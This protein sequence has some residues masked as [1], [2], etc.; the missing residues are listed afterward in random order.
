M[1]W[2]AVTDE[3]WALV[4]P[5]LP[6]PKRHRIGGGRPRVCDRTVLNAILFV[7]TT[8]CQWKALSS[9]RLC[10]P[11]TAHDRF[12]E[13]RQA[14]VF[15]DLWAVG[16]SLYDEVQGIDWRW[17]CLDGCMTKAPLAGTEDAGPNPTD[18][19]K[20]GVKRSLLTDA[21][22]VPLAVGV[23]G[24]NRPDLALALD[25]LDDIVVPR[26]RPSLE[27][28]QGLC[29]DKGYD[30]LWLRWEI[31]C[32][33]YDPHIRTRGEEAKDRRAEPGKKA[34]RWPVERTHSWINRFRRLLIRWE[35]RTDNF[36]AMLHFAFALICVQRAAWGQSG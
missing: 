28:P 33:Q 26:P 8:G 29:L 21:A 16:L 9:T 2:K 4:E 12:Q 1:S 7:L 13:W 32:R 14:G 20:L 6:A 27:F 23:A 25:T 3:F 19:A 30:A 35:K 18:R 22:G 5:L 10:A 36:L 17:L 24:A 11:S 31:L 34:R 15:R